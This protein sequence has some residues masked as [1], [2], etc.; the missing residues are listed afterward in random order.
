MENGIETI[1]FA[2]IAGEVPIQINIEE[3]EKSLDMH[4]S[5]EPF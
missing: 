2:C 3:Q 5:R 4:N 1:I